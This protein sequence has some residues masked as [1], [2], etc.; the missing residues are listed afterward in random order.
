LGLAALLEAPMG[1]KEREAYLGDHATASVGSG[2]VGESL[3][4]VRLGDRDPAFPDGRFSF[5]VGRGVR[6][7]EDCTAGDQRRDQGVELV[8]VTDA[9]IGH[10]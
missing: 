8:D 2:G 6:A 1:W 9:S 5:V 4:R 7:P 10:F 3:Q